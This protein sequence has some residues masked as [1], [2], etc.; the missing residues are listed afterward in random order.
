MRQLPEN[1]R[2]QVGLTSPWSLLILGAGHS[3][4]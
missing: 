4:P 2:V 1:M 3:S